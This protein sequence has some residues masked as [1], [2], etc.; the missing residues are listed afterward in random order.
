MKTFKLKQEKEMLLIETDLTKFQTLD[1][2][3]MIAAREYKRA[4]KEADLNR[5]IGMLQAMT[6]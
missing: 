1:R 3:I 2:L 4:G 5:M 6:L